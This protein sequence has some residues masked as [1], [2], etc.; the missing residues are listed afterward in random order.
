MASPPRHFEAKPMKILASTLM[1][2]S[3]LGLIGVPAS[4]FD[5]KAFCQE[6]E[7]RR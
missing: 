4:A 5:P 3:V 1:A 7:R 6:Q 2:L